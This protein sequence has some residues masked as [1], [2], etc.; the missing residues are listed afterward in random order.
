MKPLSKILKVGS[1]ELGDY[2]A[3]P[4][5][6][7]RYVHGRLYKSAVGIFT[8]TH[9]EPQSLERLIGK[10][11][12]KYYYYCS[13]PGGRYQKDW[14]FIGRVPFDEPDAMWPPAM[15]TTDGIY[16][17]KPQVYWKGHFIDVTEEELKGKQR[18]IVYGF[19]SLQELV[20]G[21][22]KDPWKKL[23]RQPVGSPA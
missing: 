18:W 5:L 22:Y 19:V 21:T 14:V 11:P 2:V 23:S 8:G 3:I 17:I 6:D 15:S 9:V 4:R 7:G 12:Q 1:L 13:L 20:S 10:T 16:K